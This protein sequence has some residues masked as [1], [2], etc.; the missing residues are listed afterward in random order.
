MFIEVT[1]SL[2]PS[3]FSDITNKCYHGMRT[4]ILFFGVI[5]VDIFN[6]LDQYTKQIKDRIAASAAAVYV[7]KDD[8]IIHEWYSGNHIFHNGARKVDEFS[9]FNVNSTRVTYVGLAAAIAINDNAIKGL[10]DPISKYLSNYDNNILGNTTIRHLVTRTTGLQFLGNG[11]VVRKYEE[12]TSFEGKKPEVLA[13]IIKNATGKTV[14]EIIDERV[15]KPL[16]LTQTEWRTEGKETLVCDINDPNSY[17]TLSRGLGG[18][19]TAGVRSLFGGEIKEYTEMIKD[20][21]KSAIDRMIQNAPQIYGD[22]FFAEA[23]CELRGMTNT[24]W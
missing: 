23:I 21:R 9:Q 16:G 17:P 6:N 19:I 18:N 14:A 2:A 12:G 7:M 13:A 11:S 24:F 10:D 3:P 20:T 4:N 15:L 5:R 22:F 8:E 1:G